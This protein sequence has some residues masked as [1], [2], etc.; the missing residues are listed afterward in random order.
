MSYSSSIHRYQTPSCDLNAHRF[1]IRHVDSLR[2]SLSD[3]LVRAH[4]HTYFLVVDTGKERKRQPVVILLSPSPFVL[5]LSC[6][7]FFFFIV[8]CSSS[9]LS[10]S[11]LRT[12]VVT[13]VLKNRGQESRDFEAR[14]KLSVGIIS[15]NEPAVRQV[16]GYYGLRE[17]RSAPLS[18][19]L[20]R[21]TIVSL[22]VCRSC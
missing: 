5:I 7:F 8:F 6:L 13:V 19:I 16:F 10:S 4:V 22:S 11:L 14:L 18:A 17:H 20:H 9:S 12:R 15:M 1:L 3:G 21:V 2:G